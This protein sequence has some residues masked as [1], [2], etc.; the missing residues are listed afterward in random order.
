MKTNEKKVIAI[1]ITITILV[2]IIA[3]IMGNRGK[4]SEEKTSENSEQKETTQLLN[5][6]MIL[7]NSDKLHETKKIEGMEISNIQLTESE[8]ETLLIGTIT[9]TSTT[10]QGDY[11]ALIKMVDEQGNEIKT[12][13]AYLGK[14]KPEKSMKFSASAKFDISNVYDFVITKK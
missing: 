10:E 5:D 12:M 6:G 13:E 3:I 1:L 14:L 9:N 8:N 7:N 4:K 11:V 2:I